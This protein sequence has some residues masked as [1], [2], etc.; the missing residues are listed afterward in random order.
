MKDKRTTTEEGPG[1]AI[2]RRIFAASM[3]FRAAGD[4]EDGPGTLIGHPVVY[5]SRSLD[6]GGWYEE[7]APGAFTESL[8]NEEQVALWSHDM[9]D[10]LGA[11][12]SKT[13][14]LKDSKESIESR[15]KLPDTSAGRDA[16]VLVKRGD[17][18][19]MSFGFWTQKAR[20]AVLE[21]KDGRSI[22]LR[23][24]LRGRLVEVSPVAF[25][26]YPDTDVAMRSFRAYRSDMQ[27]RRLQLRRLHQEQ[28]L[29]E[30]RT[31]CTG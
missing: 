29:M 20:W 2:E 17:V 13:L 26:A 27:R 24:V 16:A 21:E 9:R 1:A 30:R 25:P 14:A 23:T 18:S 6:L 15:I 8:R 7:I 28:Q 3:E 5:N 22:Y 19:K 10:V 11:T 4:G 31:R 12:A